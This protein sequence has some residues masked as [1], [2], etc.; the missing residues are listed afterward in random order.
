[1]LLLFQFAHGGAFSITVVST[2]TIFRSQLAG[3]LF[4]CFTQLAGLL[5]NGQFIY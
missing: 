3:H 1:M 2:Y 4:N 5:V